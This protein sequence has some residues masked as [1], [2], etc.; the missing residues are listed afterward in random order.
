MPS[1][2]RIPKIRGDL[3]PHQP[4]PLHSGTQFSSGEVGGETLHDCR[5]EHCCLSPVYQVAHCHDDIPRLQC[6]AGHS[7]GTGRRRWGH[8]SLVALAA[9]RGTGQIPRFSLSVFDSLGPPRRVRAGTFGRWGRSPSPSTVIIFPG[10]SSAGASL[11]WR[12]RRSL[13]RGRRRNCR[14]CRGSLRTW[15]NRTKGV[16]IR[17]PLPSL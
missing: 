8:Q 10:R 9:V 6:R 17:M 14:R 16:R 12:Y 5:H 1:Q 11:R 15:K 13:D 3:T 2:C 7:G 4:Q